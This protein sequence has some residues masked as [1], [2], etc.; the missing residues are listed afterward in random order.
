MTPTSPKLRGLDLDGLFAE[1]LR[2]AATQSPV[3]WEAP[4]AED[5]KGVLEGYEIV[6][7]IGRGGMG[8]VY[9]ARQ[10]HLG[11]RVAV[12]VL[13]AE[14]GAN[15]AFAERFRREARALGRLEHGNILEVFEFGESAAGHLFYSMQYID[16]GDLGARL[17]SGPLPQVEALRMVKEICAAL[18]AAHAQGVIHRD[19]KPSNI[20]LTGEGTVKVGDFGIAVLDDQ[21]KERLTYTGVAVGTMEYAAPEQ[22]A[23]NAVDSRSDLYSVGVICYEVLTG[24]LPRGI[25]DPPSKVNTSVDPSVDPVVHTAM[26][27]DPARRYQS[28]TDFRAALNRTATPRLRPERRRGLVTTAVAL[29]AAA[30]GLVFWWPGKANLPK[31]AA[32]PPGAVAT[33]EGDTIVSWGRNE[34]GEGTP[35]VG[36]GKVR[37]LAAGDGFTMA[38]KSDGTVAAWGRNDGGQTNVPAGL[39]G[40][41]AIA[42]G[43]YHALALKSDGT[44]V[45]W[46]A[47]NVGQSSIPADLT[48]VQAITAGND[49]SAA[50][51]SDGTFVEWG[52]NARGQ[53]SEAHRTTRFKAIAA[54]QFHVLAVK[55]DGTV[56]AWGDN[57]EGRTAIPPGLA[58]VRT[59][60]AHWFQGIALKEDGTVVS[61]GWRDSSM[62]TKDLTAV[63]AIA[64]GFGHTMVLKS[65]GTVVAW[66]IGD[67]SAPDGQA[68]VPAGLTG[69]KAIAAGFRHS[70][71]L[72]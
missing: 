71:V 53:F 52:S 21:P 12:K 43:G 39:T 50:L 64:A 5:L 28:A 57:G 22:A 54:G 7:L 18:E 16:G 67:D 40:V 58:G 55:S 42:A 4:S 13:P 8:A 15:E 48:G 2:E 72:K 65:D 27:S 62:H 51:K 44:V 32:A 34:F 25:F 70:V 29:L 9:E 41:K 14:L 17:K 24:Q 45:A 46:G 56:V 38:L 36:L 63:R 20:L 60:A 11:R 3:A 31:E 61:W 47:N 33:V 49:F 59:V 1:G 26:Q 6:R 68:S 30:I 19:I 10:V 69:V 23:G 66:A 37:A 35:P